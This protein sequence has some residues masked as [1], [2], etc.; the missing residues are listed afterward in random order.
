MNGAGGHR[1][2]G[3]VQDIGAPGGGQVITA[4][5]V[6]RHAKRTYVFV[7]TS[8]GT[9]A[10][11]L[12]KARLHVAW[13]SGT[14]GTSPVLAGGLLYVFD[15]GGHLDV[16]SPTTGHLLA[17]LPAAGGHWNSPIVVGGRVILPVGDANAHAVS[18]QLF[19]YHL[20]GR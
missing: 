14:P 2:G 18:G 10:Y 11:V 7:A 13:K 6:W 19:I 16:L 20:P 1:L 17:S 12:H 4:P 15:P 9:W 5:V 8:G 3:E